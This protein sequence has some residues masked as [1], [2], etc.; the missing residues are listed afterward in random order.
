MNPT[1]RS[2]TDA[3]ERIESVHRQ[4]GRVFLVSLGAAL[5]SLKLYPMENE[6]VQRAL[7]DLVEGA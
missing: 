1:R 6:Q 7:N 2:L 3:V 4:Q 5:R